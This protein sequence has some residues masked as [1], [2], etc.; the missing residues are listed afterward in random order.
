V[1]ITAK[2]KL[3][4][5]LGKDLDLT[6]GNI[7]FSAERAAHCTMADNGIEDVLSL[8]GMP[9]PE[10]Y[11]MELSLLVLEAGVRLLERERSPTTSS[12]S[13]R[14]VRQWLMSSTG[15]STIASADSMR[16][17]PSWH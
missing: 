1:A 8:V 2:D 7:C 10:M 6:R 14:Q 15:A 11:S 12:T 16:W 13:M 9:Q 5:Q 3:R 17:G 4:L